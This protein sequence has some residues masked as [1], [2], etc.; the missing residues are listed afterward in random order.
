MTTDDMITY[1]GSGV[2]SVLSLANIENIISIIALVI[3]ILT[4]FS[5]LLIKFVNKKKG[6]KIHQQLLNEIFEESEENN[7]EIKSE[8]KKR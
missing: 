5:N 2:A 3:S 4:T 6:K 8:Q 1:V 7:N